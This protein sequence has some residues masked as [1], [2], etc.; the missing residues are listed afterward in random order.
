M[1]HRGCSHPL[2]EDMAQR[3]SA[4]SPVGCPPSGPSGSGTP[5]HSQLV[6]KGPIRLV[7]PGGQRIGRLGLE[8]VVGSLEDVTVVAT[9]PDGPEPPVA[10][11]AHAPD[12]LRSDIGLSGP[13]GRED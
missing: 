7:I 13:T 4:M 2:P 3:E 12:L 9:A 10:V 5:S 6:A 1:W 11:R 8:R